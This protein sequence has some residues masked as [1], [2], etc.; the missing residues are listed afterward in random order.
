M[1]SQKDHDTVFDKIRSHQGRTT[2]SE[3]LKFRWRY[4]TLKND[5][6]EIDGIYPLEIPHSTDR[7]QQLETQGYVFEVERRLHHYLSGLFTLQQQQIT[8][9]N[10]V[11]ESFRQQ[12][13]EIKN[14]Y[15]S[16]EDSRVI[17]GLRHYVQHENV[18][19][20]KSRTSKLDQTR[21]LVI[22]VENLHR[23]DDDRNFEDHFGHIEEP[24]FDPVNLIIENRSAVIQ[25]Y[26]ST[27]DT[28]EQQKEEEIQEVHE[29]EREAEELF[30]EI[31]RELRDR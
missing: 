6:K 28:I 15:M 3:V 14:G 4:T 9:Q 22:P 23:S 18:L 24:Y 5:Y 12:L 17:L 2:I 20:L 13:Q 7:S 8:L 1:T 27:L 10:S 31:T 11:G 26:E 29:M 19:P 30:E 25:F 21:S 16:R